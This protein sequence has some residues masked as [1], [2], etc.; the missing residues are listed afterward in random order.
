MSRD[1][2]Y[3]GMGLLSKDSQLPGFARQRGF[4]PLC[5]KRNLKRGK[6]NCWGLSNDATILMEVCSKQ[7]CMCD[8]LEKKLLVM[9]GVFVTCLD[10]HVS[11][12][13]A[14]G[15]EGPGALFSCI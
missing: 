11:E 10:Q 3:L 9:S 7:V 4:R 12:P 15:S 6:S 8:V 5:I 13:M 14:L 1:G 2:A